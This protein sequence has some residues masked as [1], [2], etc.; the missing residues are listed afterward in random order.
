MC[1][2]SMTSTT[3]AVT[4]TAAPHV[5]AFKGTARRAWPVP[6]RNGSPVERNDQGIS[7]PKRTAPRVANVE[8]SR[9]F[10]EFAR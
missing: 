7:S 8:A 4:I 10:A 5:V 3:R 1:C 6:C 2:G 9:S